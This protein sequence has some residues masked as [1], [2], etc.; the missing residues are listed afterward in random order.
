MTLSDTEQLIVQGVPFVAELPPELVDLVT[1]L[2]QER[3]YDFG[4]V[5]VAEGDE[6]DGMYVLTEGLA[7]VVV[8]RDGAEVALDRLNPGDCFG[9]AALLNVTTR[10]ATVRASDATKAVFLDKV[11]FD[12]LLAIHPQAREA[13]DTQGDVYR[14][15]R[16]LRI[17]GSFDGLD[18]EAARLL[19]PKL[20]RMQVPAGTEVVR[21]GEPGKAFY[22]VEHGRLE[23][24][25]DDEAERRQIGFLRVGDFFGERSLLLDEPCVATVRA[26]TDSTL[27]SLD[28][29][30]F[31]EISEEIPAF[32]QRVHEISAGR[33]YRASA[34]LSLDFGLEVLPGG[35]G[36]A[37]GEDEPDV[38][39]SL[40]PVEARGA[41]VSPRTRRERKFPFVSQI[42]EMD[43]GA[44][45][46]AMV[47]KWHGI[48]VGLTFIRD[49]AAVSVSGTTLKAIRMAGGRIGLDI[50][51]RKV[52]M[53][54]VGTVPLPAIIHWEGRHW[55]VLVE[56]SDEGAKLADPGI[57]MRT[58]TSEELAKHWDGYAAIVQPAADR[59]VLPSS[60]PNLRWLRP[61]I[62]AHKRA[63]TY[64]LGL[65]LAA[66]GCEVALP[67]IVETIVNDVVVP[68]AE[69]ALNLLGLVMLALVLGGTAAGLMQR[70]VLVA[71][72]ARFD[73]ATL[74]FVTTRLLGLP[75]SYFASRR[76]GD[77][78][79]RLSGVKEIRRIVVQLGIQAL[80]DLTQVLAGIAIMFVLAPLLGVLFVIVVPI[81]AVVMRYSAE[82]LRP[83]YAG[84]EES[85]GRYSSD[86]VDLLKGI[87]TVKSTATEGGLRR[88]LRQG[89]TDFNRRTMRSYRTIAAYGSTLQLISLLSYILFVFAGSV[90]VHD[91]HLSLGA[92]V[93]FITLVMLTTTPLVSLLSIW[94]DVQ[95]SS[96]LLNRIAD[97][98]EHE[99]EQGAAKDKLLPVPSLEGRVQL[100]DLE[101]TPPNGEQ[102]IVA[103]VTL[104]VEP[105]TTVAVVGRS[106]SGKSTL[107]RL[108][109]GLLEPTAGQIL[110]DRVD[111]TALRYE[112]LRRQLGLVLQQPYVFATTIAKNIA[113]GEEVPDLQ[114]V[115][116]AA[117][118]ADLAEMVDRLP[119][120]YDTPVGD[121]GLPLSGGQSQRLAIARALYREPPVLLFDEATSALDT[122][123]ESTVKRNIDRVL[124]NRTAFVVAHRL[125]TI[126][127][128]DVILVMERGRVV[129]Q[130]THDEL[131]ERQGIYYYL[132]SQQFTSQ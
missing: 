54:R 85:F 122:E 61:F 70:L 24:L 84:I 19:Y 37:G 115:H 125:S 80:T 13:L 26:V 64:A 58:V 11:V 40:E 89:F 114:A 12:A 67:I 52:S 22:L 109:A 25:R 119:L 32:F 75:I 69:S 21:E 99:P 23:V 82:R 35:T 65:A 101:Y 105:G 33:D 49:A 77:I 74:D 66:A 100:V 17:Q 92:F 57:G 124:V 113:L 72:T 123:S 5:I 55:V 6:A 94:D 48:D 9:E 47:A 132:H 98:L 28:R 42:D 27:L 46:L 68:H 1:R 126:R 20:Q 18:A 131:L 91:H 111:S 102:A 71:A 121:S 38:S 112:D 129:E 10:N 45:C 34:L 130:G 62:V 97:I 8:T 87:E 50:E 29:P 118:I 76:T 16:L 90:E 63:L 15:L 103:G 56:A 116:K 88:T 39:A 44:A 31:T 43:C 128:A 73:V 2:F 83:L 36:E 93:A 60:R 81:Y 7:R 4:D 120:G 41:G 30:D 106:G 117:E 14:L 96:V 104:T 51:P 127:D 3:Q 59:P 110:F 108:L 78:E 107:L 53:E 79:R 95:I 86:Q